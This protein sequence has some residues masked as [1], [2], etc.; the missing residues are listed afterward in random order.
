MKAT[1]TI[2]SVIAILL[3]V[4]LACVMFFMGGEEAPEPTT[5]VT[6]T[7]T[8]TTTAPPTEPPTTA[9]PTTEPTEPP[10]EASHTPDTD[11]DAWGVQWAIMAGDQ[12]VES[13]ERPDPIFF[14]GEDYFA[15]PG[16]ATFRG[17]SY[18]QDASYGTAQIVE[19]SLNQLSKTSV[20]FLSEA[21]WI[22]C[23]WTGQPLIVKWDAQTRQ[24]MNLYEEKKNK[25]DLVEVI[26]AKMDGRI[27]FLDLEDGSATRDPMYV[28]MV[29]KGSGALDPRGYPILYVG[30][31]LAQNGKQPTMFIIDLINCQVMKEFNG[32]DTFSLRSWYA[33]DSCPL[34]DADTDTLIWPGESGIL[35]TMRLNAEYDREAGLVSVEPEAPVKTHYTHTYRQQGR[36]LGYESSAVVVE[37]YAYLGDNSGMLQCIDLNTMQM[38]WTQDIV[39][40]LNSTPLFDWGEDG[41]GYL[42]LC[43]SLEF[44]NGGTWNDLPICKIDAR[45][46]E[47]IWTHELTCCTFDGVS[48]GA[49]ASPLLGRPGTNMEDLLIY[50]VGR[51]PSAWKGQVVALDKEDGHVVWQYETANYMW[52]SPVGIY[53]EDGKGYVFQADASGNCYLLDGATGEKLSSVALKSTVE[54]SPVVYGN[55]V[56]LGSRSGIHIFE[57]K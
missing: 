19:G 17:G 43:P 52:S 38:V 26:Y 48:G 51:S 1:I 37:Q 30:S 7:V 39:D 8:P 13:Y 47:I 18:R 24:H 2:L 50:S 6:T 41:N 46:G 11:P 12:L 5:Q 44:S 10:F 32:Y 31:G 21:E 33:F 34:V 40:D 23:G 56:V 36:N 3:L 25:E 45:T 35:Y 49:L 54:A 16:V 14:S 55:R 28:G 4:A 22:G 9:A 42:Y 15:L 27:H 29:F 57:I 20:G 53:T